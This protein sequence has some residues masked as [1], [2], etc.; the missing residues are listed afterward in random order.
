M[1][2]TDYRKKRDFKRTPEPRGARE[3]PSADRGGLYVIQKHAASRL[4]YDLRLEHRG[5][6][7]SWAVPKGPSLNPKDK[8]LAVEVEDHPVEYAAFEGVIPEGQYGAGTVLL[9]DRGRWIPEG[10]PEKA[11]RQGKLGFRLEGEKLRGSWALV[12]LRGDD[13][14]PNWLLIKAP[15]E[16]A[17]P[18]GDITMERPES[19]ATGRD[20]AGVAG[21]TTA[22]TWH[23]DRPAE[24]EPVVLPGH[25]KPRNK[26]P[27]ADE[28]R[29]PVREARVALHEGK[30][31]QKTIAELE[32][33]EE[34]GGDGRLHLP[35]GDTLEVT[36][37]TKVFWPGLG[38]TKGGLLRH[39]AR[40]SPYLLPAVQDRPLVMRR[41]PN[42]ITGKAF[43]QQRAPQDVPR[44]VRVE[45]VQGDEDV[46]GR[47]V[48]G[49]LKTL[50]YMAQ[51]AV[52][53][54]DPWVSRVRT[55]DLPDH[56]A[57]D[58]DPMPD[59]PWSQV[60]D[61]ARWCHDELQRIGVPAW[62]KTS[63]AS[64][65]HIY[66]PLPPKTSYESGR[67][68]CEVIAAIIARRHPRA[69]T[70]KRAVHA[71]GRTVYVDY[72]QN[73]R[74]KTLATAYSVRASEFAGVSTPLTWDEVHRGVDTRD[75][76]IQT[77]AARL[78]QVGD[79]WAGLRTSDGVDF[80]TI[81]DKVERARDVTPER[82]LFL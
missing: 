63:G 66:I 3:H 8:R 76:T 56:V 27:K 82:R 25:A 49:S 71:R 30:I 28:P 26:P 65:L 10:D 12:R 38:I 22:K 60:L 5:V 34:R 67:L 17:R 16:T 68:L 79:L 64:G 24:P 80:R 40:V 50:L 52:I 6:L 46:P 35:G 58:L 11:F 2:L 47:L 7:K 13:G 59:V 57:L 31:I 44:G 1:A 36:N 75:F 15:D 81:L 54:Q 43:Y 39:Y 74:G 4:H 41:F 23:S 42:G 29:P 18:H 21:N 20:L 72:L 78:Q 73:M 70:V 51:L 53:A 33:I 45:V 48:G 9:W 61:V 62:P 55:P 14:K 32:G 77:I 37:L 19:V 69:A